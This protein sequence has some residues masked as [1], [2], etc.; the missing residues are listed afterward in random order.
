[1]KN[2]DR[3]EREEKREEKKESLRSLIDLIKSFPQASK[4]YWIKALFNQD[5]IDSSIAGRLIIESEIL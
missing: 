2:Q 1:M 5:K 3:Q 4:S